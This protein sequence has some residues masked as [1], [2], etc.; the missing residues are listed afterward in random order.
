[1]E[2]CISSVVC[3]QNCWHGATPRS[4]ES[5]DSWSRTNLL[6]DYGEAALADFRTTYPDIAPHADFLQP[7][8]DGM[9]HG[10][11]V[12]LVQEWNDPT[13]IGAIHRRRH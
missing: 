1:M 10:V 9:L 11:D 6:R 2:A 12:V 13:L 8:I 3:C 5:R 4:F 7:D